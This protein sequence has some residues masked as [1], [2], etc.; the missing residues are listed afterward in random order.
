MEDGIQSLQG[1]LDEGYIV[2]EESKNWAPRL[3]LWKLE[4]FDIAV[5]ALGQKLLS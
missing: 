1:M 5:F 2:W 4:W 3:V